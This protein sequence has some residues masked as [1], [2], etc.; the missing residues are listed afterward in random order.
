A[1]F[2]QAAGIKLNVIL[3]SPLPRAYQ[4][5]EIVA[6]KLDLEVTEEPVLGPGFN[7]SKLDRLLARYKSPNVMLVGH[8]PGLTQAIKTLTG[9]KIKLAKGGLARVDLEDAG[10][11]RGQLVWLVPPKVIDVK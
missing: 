11:L 7:A 8:S 9:A 5:A 3:S 1:A 10:V 6:G 2:L 4:T